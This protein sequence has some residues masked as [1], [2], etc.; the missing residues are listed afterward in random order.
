MAVFENLSSRLQGVLSKMRGQSR[1]TEADIQAMM[2]E[3]RLALL[4]ADVHYQVVKDLVREIGE[5]CKG[6]EVLKGLAPG[7]QVVKVVHESLI[8][9]L[10]S[11][12]KKLAVNPSGFTVYILYGLQGSGK[13]TTAA[14]LARLLKQKGKKPLVTSVD[15]HR[16]AAAKQLDIL[17]QQISVPCHI[18]P[19]EPQAVRIAKEAIERARYLLCDTLIV[20]TAGRM[21]VDEELMQELEVLTDAVKPDARLL[22]VDAMI[23]QEA[24]HTAQAFQERIGLD[25]FIMTKLDGDARGGAALSISKMT[26]CPIQFIGVGEKVDALEDFHADRMASRILGMGDVLSLIEKAQQNLDAEAM[27][28]TVERLARNQFSLDDLLNQMLQMKKMGSVKDLIGMVPGIQQAKVDESQLDDRLI[29]RNIAILRA[30]TPKERRNAQLLNASRRKRI[31]R[32]SGT[33]VSD[34]NRLVRQFEDMQKMMKQFGFFGGKKKGL[35]SLMRMGRG[36]FP[37]GT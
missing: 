15:T 25:G 14:K 8:E 31:A 9:L 29:D 11:G 24:V 17:C 4:E 16:P 34:V 13:T 30:M 35:R 12:E 10:Q 2:R 19:E 28:E 32:G 22:V 6:A 7:Q 3:I 5:K 23:G 20:D 21:T 27:Q 26:G 1:V 37:F 36:G 33:A 18:H